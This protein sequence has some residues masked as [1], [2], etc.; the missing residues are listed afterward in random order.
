M[1][2]LNLL[3]NDIDKNVSNSKFPKL[4]QL[5][6]TSLH[7][8]IYTLFKRQLTPFSLLFGFD[9]TFKVAELNH[10][11]YADL[12]DYTF[13]IGRETKF[14]IPAWEKINSLKNELDSNSSCNWFWFADADLYIVNKSVSLISLI[15]EAIKVHSKNNEHE[16]EMIFG[17]DYSDFVINAGS[18][19]IRNS[20]FIKNFIPF[21]L[22]LEKEN[23]PL[24][25]QESFAVLYKQNFLNIQK[26]SFITP[27][28]LFN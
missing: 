9:E 3:D 14:K 5:S 13:L 18:F 7:I 17:Q 1:L 27:M 4:E 6:P 28:V 26:R 10:Q 8:C 23:Y 11:V 24:A 12:H 22:D 21:W 15:E 2:N 19:L 25:E 20:L 16:L